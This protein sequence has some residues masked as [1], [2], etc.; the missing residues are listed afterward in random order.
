MQPIVGDFSRSACGREVEDRLGAL[1]VRFLAVERTQY[2]DRRQDRWLPPSARSP[3]LT[4]A[5]SVTAWLRATRSP[6]SRAA[7]TSFWPPKR[8]MNCC[9]PRARYPSGGRSAAWRNRARR[10]SGVSQNFIYE[11]ESGQKPGTAATLKK[12]AD[13]LKLRVDDLIW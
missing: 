12:L 8:R 7:K 10:C 4:G 1:Y 11:I 13:V 9:P 6:E 3:R 2:S 5:T